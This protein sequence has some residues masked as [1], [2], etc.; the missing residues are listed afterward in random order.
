[1]GNGN[2][3]RVECL[4]HSFPSTSL[5]DSIGSS[6]FSALKTLSTLHFDVDG[7]FKG[8]TGQQG[9]PEHRGSVSETVTSLRLVGYVVKAVSP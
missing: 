3:G 9:R 8:R 2:W 4:N 6:Y 7:L 1:M 5:S